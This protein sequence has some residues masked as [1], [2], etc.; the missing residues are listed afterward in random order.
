MQVNGPFRLVGWPVQELRA[1]TQLMLLS[2]WPTGTLIILPMVIWASGST[3]EQKIASFKF[4]LPDVS[5]LVSIRAS[6][7]RCSSHYL[8]LFY[9]WEV[10]DPALVPQQLLFLVPQPLKWW[11]SVSKTV[12]RT[13]C[14]R[15]F[16][17]WRCCAHH[18]SQYEGQAEQAERQADGHLGGVTH[19][20]LSAV[21]WTI[22]TILAVLTDFITANWE[23]KHLGQHS[24]NL[25]LHT[26]S[27]VTQPL[28]FITF[29]R[30]ICFKMLGLL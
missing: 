30:F 22:G 4:Q 9:G 13:V 11:I 7:P 14:K 10:N 8:T 23:G 6:S 19:G 29:L 5:G 1:V 15:L 25:M 26:L 24:S 18:C 21:G 20:T 27:M 2:V 28:D 12:N 17:E 16:A 3:Q